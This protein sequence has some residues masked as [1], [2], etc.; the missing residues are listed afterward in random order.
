V[1]AL[2]W[3]ALATAAVP[4]LQWTSGKIVYL[5]DAAISSLYLVGFALCISAGATLAQRHRSTLLD[6][7]GLA[8][9]AAGIVSVGLGLIQWLGLASSWM[10]A[11]LPRG[12]RPFANLAQ[13]NHLCTLLGMA[14]V[15]TIRGFERRQ[16]S[17]PVASLA[18]AWFS[19]GIAM[20]QSRTGWLFVAA[21]VLWWATA[22]TRA[23]LRLSTSA[24]LTGAV[25]FVAVVVSWPA[26]NEALM[27]TAHPLEARLQPGTRLL[28][29]QTLLDAAWRAPWAGYGWTQVSLAQ[30]AAALD[31]PASHEWIL[32][33]HNLA[34]D[35]L[36]WNGLP[37]GGALIAVLA[38]WFVRQLTTCDSV[39]RWA[40]LLAVAVVFIHAALEFPLDYTYFL[41]P[42]GLMMGAA[43]HLRATKDARA[44]PSIA[45]PGFVAVLVVACGVSGWAVSDYLRV[46]SAATQLRFVMARI[47][48][49][50]VSEA[51]VPETVL[52]DALREFHRFLLTPAKP[53]LGAQELEA[54]RDV[55]QRYPVPPAMLRY[56]LMAGLNGRPDEAS[57]TL[58]LLCKIHSVERCREAHE[59]WTQLRV[60][61]PEL[62][63]SADPLA[64]W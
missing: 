27:L 26:I 52:L 25:A 8:L 64:R 39:D 15:M 24:V 29:W 62:A 30:L 44:L 13:P 9:I 57:T 54:A 60:Q 58:A 45:R 48:V 36:I 63:A 4:W 35:L 43:D 53:G 55:M 28:H 2:A 18:V 17:G 20:T 51:P 47:G 46:Q 3:V 50:K 23:G 41:F 5:Q 31:H 59:S 38:W 6:G 7:L 49:D 42:A 11:N 34:V 21:L 33:S 22:R 19:F 61:Y 12:G 56:A 37:L 32:N 40:L 16:L 1:P 14:A 10:V